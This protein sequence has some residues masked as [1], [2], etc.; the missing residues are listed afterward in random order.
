MNTKNVTNAFI[1]SG[2]ILLSNALYAQESNPANDAIENIIIVGYPADVSGSAHVLDK[3]ELSIFKAS[4]MLRMLRS[5]PG[6]YIQEE[7]GF[8][9]RPN[10]GIRGSGI[11]RSGKIAVMEDGVL[12]AP[13]PYTASSAYYFPTARRMSA[14]E[15]LKGPSAVA[16]GPRTTGGALN[17][18]STQIPDEMGM[19]GELDF[20]AGNHDLTDT[21]AYLGNRG[22][23]FSWLVE[24]VQQHTNGFKELDGP[25]GLDNGDTG[26]DI[27]DYMVKMQYDTDSSADLYQSLRVKLGATQQ[28]SNETYLGLTDADYKVNPY[29]RY[30]AS[31]RD[32]FNGH[33]EQ[34]QLSY[35][36]DNNDNWRGEVTVYD[37]DFHRDW[38]KLQKIGGKSQS[39]ITSDPITNAAAYAILTGAVTSAD[40][41]IVLRHN[42]RFY[43]SKGVQGKFSYD[44]DM[45]GMDTTI[46]VGFR[47][48]EDYEDRKQREDKFRMENMGLVTTTLAAPSSKTNRFS[49]SEVTSFFVSADM[50]MGNLSLSPG[51][52]IEELD[53]VRYDYSTSDPLRTEG[54][55]KT[56][57]RSEDATIMGIGAMYKLSD[58]LRLI[59]GVHQG[60]QPPGAGSKAKA[61]ESVNFEFGARTTLNDSMFEIIAFLSDYDNIVGTVTASTG[62]TADI[63]SQYDGGAV[64][65]QGLE[66]GASRSITSS[67]GFEIPISLQY[68]LTSK[69]EFETSFESSFDGWGTAV[70]KGDRLPYMPKSQLRATIGVIG[71]SMSANLSANYASEVRAL[72]GQGGIPGNQL[73]DAHWVLDAIANYKVNENVSAYVKI[74][75]LLDEVYLA[76]RRPA[77]I[78]PGMDRQISVGINIQ[79]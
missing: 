57:R 45:S 39:A 18:V 36:V 49:K 44:F 4:D 46:N 33:H 59:A 31:A 43:N 10:I 47:V 1:I 65:V 17:M 63:G 78:R 3:E 24:T 38:F 73:I 28:T 70:V 52:R 60:Y 2:L 56:K 6:V 8:G 14:I 16:V 76:A 5:V 29:R 75:N 62:G 19:S 20:R 54:P 69:A 23:R 27:Q 72:A 35:I 37:N 30:A 26:F 7:D 71:E 51:I 67:S 34:I 32:Q 41:A 15:V 66:I 21:H 58:D 53:N 40:D 25:A 55:T 12:I 11:D 79:L 13:A 74:D 9:L 22:E 61:E 42:N 77:G 64:K 50:I 48:H 68:T